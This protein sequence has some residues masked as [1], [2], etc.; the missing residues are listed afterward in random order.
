MQNKL[1]LVDTGRF[2]Q[3]AK[4][5]G[6]KGHDSGRPH[7]TYRRRTILTVAAVQE[8]VCAKYYHGNE[9]VIPDEDR[10]KIDA[11]QSEVA[12]INGWKD[13]F[14]MLPAIVL[15]VPYG[16]LADRIGRKVFLLA[17]VGIAMNDFWMRIVFW[18]PDFFGVRALSTL[19]SISHVTVA[20]VCPSDQRTTAFSQ[21][22]FAM[23][24]AQFVFVSIGGVLVSVNPWIPMLISSVVTFMGFAGACLFL[25]E[26][27]PPTTTAERE[28]PPQPRNGDEHG[29]AVS[30]HRRRSARWVAANGRLVVVLMAFFPATLDQQAGGSL[31]LHYAAKRFNWT[32]GS[33]SFLI[34]LG[35]GIN[36]VVHAISIP[37]LLSYL[38]RHLTLHEIVKDK[39]IAQ[40]SGAFLV[41]GVMTMFAPSF[42]TSM[43]LAL[44]VP[45]RSIVTSLVA[46]GHLAALYTISV[47]VYGGML[48]GGPVL[49]S[50]FH[51]GLRIGG[52]W[53]GLPYL[54]ICVCFAVALPTLSSAPS[55]GKDTAIGIE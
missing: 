19:S 55:R 52:L 32:M 30:D 16:A 7:H 39:R 25:P 18:F 12:F 24:A 28:L 5:A 33:A 46:K 29:G 14:E 27:R 50:A 2:Y 31:L 38:L 11:V 42:L 34:S 44:T 49:A 47:L 54:V 13:V 3:S 10:C 21:L 37:S 23:M 8:F 36:L 40:V 1:F 35:A 9:G 26:T 4:I 45:T 17:I 51:W 6:Q 48:A 20:D 22:Q 41:A 15:A 43:G 53:Q